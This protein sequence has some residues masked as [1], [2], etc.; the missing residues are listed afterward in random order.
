MGTITGTMTL[1][2]LEVMEDVKQRVRRGM[3]GEVLLSIDCE[4]TVEALKR[5]HAEELV[6]RYNL[7]DSYEEAVA[8][9]AAWLNQWLRF[10][11]EREAHC[12]D[13]LS[14]V[15]LAWVYAE[16]EHPS[17]EEK[18]LYW[19]DYETFVECLRTDVFMVL[20]RR[21]NKF[22]GVIEPKDTRL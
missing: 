18:Q 6:E 11:V 17:E 4:G 9:I 3:D 5:Q 1:E 8:R 20:Y 10:K 15:A 21:V 22:Y 12:A 7:V 19:R 14:L 16:R 13:I 2:Y